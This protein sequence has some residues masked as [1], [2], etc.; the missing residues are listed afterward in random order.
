MKLIL[1][2]K[3][4]NDATKL[5]KSEGRLVVIS[6]HS[7]EDRLVKNLINKGSI[8]GKSNKVFFWKSYKDIYTN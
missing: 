4:L 5:L 1:L 6:Y 8:D 3:L 2:K 7:L